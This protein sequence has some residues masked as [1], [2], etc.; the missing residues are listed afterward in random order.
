MPKR[1]TVQSSPCYISCG[2]EEPQADASL[3]APTATMPSCLSPPE[4]NL[5]TPSQQTALMLLNAAHVC[6]FACAHECVKLSTQVES[7]ISLGLS[8]CCC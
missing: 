5:Q 6:A 1:M 4:L 7:I 2:S 3:H 8:S